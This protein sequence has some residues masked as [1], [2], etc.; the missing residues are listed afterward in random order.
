MKIRQI[1]NNQFTVNTEKGVYFQSYDSIVC[2]KPYDGGKILLSTH[3]SYSRTTMKYLGQFLNDAKKPDIL[4]LIK[5]GK[6][7][8]IETDSLP[9]K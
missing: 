7:E 8:V 1:A 4:K 3:W 2:F 5:S 6:A 9:I